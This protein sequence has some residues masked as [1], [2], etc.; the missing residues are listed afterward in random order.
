MKKTPLH[1]H[2]HMNTRGLINFL[3]NFFYFF[4]PTLIGKIL[5]QPAGGLAGSP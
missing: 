1:K 2:Y 5:P 3:E 4:K